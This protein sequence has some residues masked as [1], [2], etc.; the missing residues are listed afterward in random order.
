LRNSP[1]LCSSFGTSTP[2]RTSSN[3][4]AHYPLHLG[5]IP[6][7]P[8]TTLLAP[9]HP[10]PLAVVF[11]LYDLDRD[12]YVGESELIATM[13]QLQQNLSEQQLEQVLLPLSLPGVAALFSSGP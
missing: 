1:R 11:S 13:K 12:G 6:S 9:S 2:Q 8:T 5:H 4:I 7:P 10:F 3:V